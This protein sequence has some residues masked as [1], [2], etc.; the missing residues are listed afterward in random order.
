L[1]WSNSLA[2]NGK[3]TVVTTINTARTNIIAT[4]NGNILTLAWPTD[5][6]GWYLQ[7]QTNTTAT[8]LYTNWVTL[9]GS[10]LVNTTNMT[11]NPA[12]G[13]VFYRMSLTP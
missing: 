1:G 13:A 11:I 10:Q 2:L 6:T 3:L 7:L 8:G 9:P 12:N 5:H 4:V